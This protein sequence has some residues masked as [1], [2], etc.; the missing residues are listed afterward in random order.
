[1]GSTIIFLDLLKDDRN[2]EEAG[3]TVRFSGTSANLLALL[4]EESGK[5]HGE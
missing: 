2:V 5:E 3:L 1:M 4:I